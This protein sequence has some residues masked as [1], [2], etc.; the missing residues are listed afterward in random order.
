[1]FRKLDCLI[2]VKKLFDIGSFNLFIIGERDLSEI[3]DYFNEL[4]ALGAD[5][6]VQ[7][8]ADYYAAQNS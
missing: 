8:Y 4:Q 2:I 3:D 5:E 6:Y 7:Y 1:M